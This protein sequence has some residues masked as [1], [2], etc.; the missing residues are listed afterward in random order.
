MLDERRSRTRHF[1]GHLMTTRIL[2]AVWLAI[3]LAAQA[4]A[5]EIPGEYRSLV[6]TWEFVAAFA[7]KCDTEL[8][9]YGVSA[10]AQHDCRVFMTELLRLKNDD[11]VQGLL[12]ESKALHEAIEQ[13]TDQ[14]LRWEW[15]QLS[16]RLNRA[17]EKITRTSE[18][19]IFLERAEREPSKP[20]SR[21]PKK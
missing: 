8:T 7:S 6:N 10:V 12:N 13:S 21:R 14:D 15:T 18:H 17:T 9:V 19:I 3:L 11:H 4:W 1:K 2:A 16:H 5:L 20:S